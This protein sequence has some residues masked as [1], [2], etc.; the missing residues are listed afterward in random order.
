MPYTTG[1]SIRI[2]YEVEGDGPTLVLGHGGGDSLEMWRKAGYT[3]ALRDEYRLVLFD[4]PGHGRSDRPVGATGANESNEGASERGRSGMGD[5]VVAVLDELG[6]D[7]AHYMGYSAGATAGFALA[8]KYPERF[9]SFILGGM[10][11]YAWP[12]TMIRAVT[13]SIDLYKLLL[14]EPEQYLFRMERLLGH[15]LTQEDKD[16]FLSQDAEARIAGL[17]SI[18]EGPALTDEELATISTPCMLYCGELDPFYPGAMEAARHMPKVRFLSLPGS[19]HITALMRSDL[20]VPFIKKFLTDV[21]Q[22]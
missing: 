18:I 4:F 5:G 21:D 10:T 6:I 3:D 22:Q 15:A 1:E 2:Y 9:Y 19:N 7:K 16:H 11:P 12:E 20:M 14:A 17:S 8:L 13:M